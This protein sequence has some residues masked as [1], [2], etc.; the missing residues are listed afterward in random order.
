[1][2]IPD[3]IRSLKRSSKKDEIPGLAG[4]EIEEQ[5]PACKSNMKKYPPCCGMPLGY[6]GCKCGYKISF[7]SQ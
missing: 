7:K 5:C 4:E 1:M 2:N 6:K 3:Y